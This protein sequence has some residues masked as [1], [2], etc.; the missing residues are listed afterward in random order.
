M[1]SLDADLIE[2]KVAQSRA[3]VADANDADAWLTFCRETDE[4][5]EPCLPYLLG[6]DVVWPTAI[7]VGPADSTVVLG[8]HDAP[9][10]EDL[11]V[12][13]VR[14]YDESMR[15]PLQATLDA[16]DAETVALNYDEDDNVADGLTH[17]MWLRLR[18]LLPDREFVPAGRLVRRM[19]GLK[20]EAELGRIERAAETTEE[21]LQT[22]ASTWTPETT[23]A[24]F[25]D[26]LHERMTERGLGSA[27]AWDYCPTVHMGGDS[28]VGHT[29]PGEHTLDDGEVLHVDFGVVKDGYAADIQRLWVRGEASD[30]LQATFRDVRAAIDAGREALRPGASGCDVDTAARSELTDR[31]HPPFEH[32]F[33]HQVGRAA[34]DGG[35]L[36]G[37][38]WDRYGDSV[39]RAVRAGEVYTMELGVDTEW[40]YV[41]QEE[42]V[43]VTDDGPEWVVPPQTAFRTL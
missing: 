25:A 43:R 32:A 35:T 5:N 39:R 7:V 16:M 10:A 27:W 11:G 24:E 21:L 3:A 17:G 1:P 20:S 29:M 34:H 28:E 8:R 26:F 15:E 9:T 14:S 33:G 18:D 37:P 41:G 30:V 6:F 23:E 12:H 38:E 40:G 31:G 42:M 22:A 4:V 2:E 13:E 36:L 19:R